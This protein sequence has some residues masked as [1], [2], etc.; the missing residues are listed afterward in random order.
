[1]TNF[2][3][4]KITPWWQRSKAPWYGEFFEDMLLQPEDPREKR[5]QAIRDGML[6]HYQDGKRK[7]SVAQALSITRSY[8][9]TEG[10]HPALRRALAM[11]RVF[12]EIPI[13]LLPGQLLMGGA[14][15]GPHIV[16]FTPEYIPLTTQ[17][18]QQGVFV[19]KALHGA[20]QRYVFTPE[21]QQV[22]EQE[23]WPYWRTHA[24]E[25]Y[26]FNEL[27]R[28]YPQAW[29]FM[30]EA[31]CARYSPLIGGGLAHSL[32]DYLSIL[33]VGLLGIKQEIQGHI[34]EPL[35]PADPPG[36][37]AFERRNIYEAM[38]IVA[39]GLITYANRN[40]DLAESLA[41]EETDPVRAERTAQDGGHL[42]QGPCPPRRKLVGGAAVLPFPARRNSPVRGRR[43][44]FRRA[45]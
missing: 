35:S 29:A 16:D 21:D 18:W 25:I 45:L 2:D 43:F 3:T 32:Q 39:D 38:L 7:L 27:Y 44:P 8:K 42:P 30:H 20:D 34:A 1:M 28:H 15:S 13:S 22:Y 24:R 17:E 37:E 11:Q 6:P 41:D 36:M 12:E 19:T 14:S 9:E 40:A 4:E 23:I 10:L 26:F 31:D 5:I 33:K